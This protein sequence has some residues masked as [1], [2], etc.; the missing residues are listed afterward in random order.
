MGKR[1]KRAVNELIPVIIND[2]D[3]EIRRLAIE[4]IGNIKPNISREIMDA[5]VIASNDENVHIRRA[6]VITAEHFDIFPYTLITLLRRRLGDSDRLVREL[7]MSVFEKIGTIGVH[8]LI[9]GLKDPN[10][11][12]RLTI[13][14]TLGRLGEDATSAVNVLKKIQFDD[15]DIRVRNAAIKAL[16][17]ITQLTKAN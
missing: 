3:P 7:A 13:V 2:P 16:D 8:N 12:M 4:A 10:P 9:R 11:E 14:V 17:T 1:A 15:E 6:A 5:L